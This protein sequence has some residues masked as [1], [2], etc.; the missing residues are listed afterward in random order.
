MKNSI[1]GWAAVLFWVAAATWIV[2]SCFVDPTEE[3]SVATI[4]LL[5]IVLGNQCETKAL[6]GA[7]GLEGR[8][9]QQ[10]PNHRQPLR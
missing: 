1:Y 7:R 10:Q 3:L 8:D 9:E 6:R 5:L 2:A 4:G